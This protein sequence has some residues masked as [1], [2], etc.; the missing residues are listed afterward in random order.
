MKKPPFL[1]LALICG[2]LLASTPAAAQYFYGGPGWSQQRS[3]SRIIWDDELRYRNRNAFVVRN[4]DRAIIRR[5]IK[6]RP[7][8][9]PPGLF[10]RHGCVPPGQYR[11]F[12]RGEFL[13]YR[14]GYQYLPQDVLVRLRRPPA[15]A[16]Y[17]RVGNDVYLIDESTREILDVVSLMTQFR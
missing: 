15:W 10:R 13:P 8:Y 17:V 16:E 1:S 5:Y 9:C 6:E 14:I 2:G 4:R 3:S 12:S 7:H 11:I